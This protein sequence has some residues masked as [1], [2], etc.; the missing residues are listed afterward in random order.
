VENGF[1]D[2][3]PPTTGV[4]YIIA[5]PHGTGWGVGKDLLREELASSRPGTSERSRHPFRR[6]IR[7]SAPFLISERES[8]CRSFFRG[9]VRD[10][11]R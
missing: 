2:H 10:C 5:Y 11:L 3:G 8:R 9:G 7:S 4:S 1:S 6:K